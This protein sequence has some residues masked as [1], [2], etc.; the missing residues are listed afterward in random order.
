[1]R[2]LDAYLTLEPDTRDDGPDPQREE[3]D[4]REERWEEFVAF[5]RDRHRAGF[6]WGL[7]VA[8]IGGLMIASEQHVEPMTPLVLCQLARR[9]TGFAETEGW[10]GVLSAVARAMTEQAAEAAE[11]ERRR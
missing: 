1:M 10:P 5:L 3:E 9:A 4:A 2:G 11:I 6:E 7:M 8:F